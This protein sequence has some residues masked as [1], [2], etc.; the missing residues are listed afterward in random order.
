MKAYRHKKSDLELRLRA[1]QPLLTL[2]R[3]YNKKSNNI[4]TVLFENMQTVITVKF[5]NLYRDSE[6]YID[7]LVSTPVKTLDIDKLIKQIKDL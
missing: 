4:I 7:I 2:V 6:P 1:L 5:L 3:S